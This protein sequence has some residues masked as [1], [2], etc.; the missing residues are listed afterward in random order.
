MRGIPFIVFRP[1]ILFSVNFDASQSP[2]SR[3]APMRC[4][5]G[6]RMPLIELN[7]VIRPVPK[8]LFSSAISGSDSP[9][10]ARLLMPLAAMPRR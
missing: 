1:P 8:R 9:N 2:N 6:F 5:G 4:C 3:I 7:A 10:S